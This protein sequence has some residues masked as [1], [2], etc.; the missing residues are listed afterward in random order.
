M[1]GTLWPPP[2]KP[3]GEIK[4]SP[5]KPSS[6]P[7]WLGWPST[8]VMGQ[9]GLEK[10][11]RVRG[12]LRPPPRRPSGDITAS[13]AQADKPTVGTRGYPACKNSPAIGG[14]FGLPRVDH[15][16][17]L[18]SPPTNPQACHPGSD[19]LPRASRGNSAWK[20]SPRGCIRLLLRRRRRRRNIGRSCRRRCHPRRRRPRRRRNLGRRRRRR[21][22]RRPVPAAPSPLPAPHPEVDG[23]QR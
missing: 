5:N 20:N 10:L 11:P 17:T 2:P 8:G 4:V 6:L 9:F 16:G 7:S 22:C 15:Q 3:S 12:T 21:R 14:P 18:R 13:P 23:R 19:G 1:R